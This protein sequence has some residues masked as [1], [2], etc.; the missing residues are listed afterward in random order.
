M[1]TLISLV[2]ISF[3]FSFQTTDGLKPVQ[4]LAGT[5]KTENKDSYEVWKINT[6]GSMEGHAYQM[7]AGEKVITEYLNIRIIDGKVTYQAKALGQNNNQ[8]IPFVL[9]TAVQDQLSFE[10][11]T[12]DFPKKIQYKALDEK[13]ILVSVLGEG[14]KG[15]RYR[16]IR[17]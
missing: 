11:P 5:W 4:F 1:K 15:F 7:K 10:N 13:T 14:D 16:I 2:I 12:H 8:T 6:D 17:Q 9:N 3:L